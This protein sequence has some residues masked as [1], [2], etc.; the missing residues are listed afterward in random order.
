MIVNSEEKSR[1]YNW[2]KKTR[3]HEQGSLNRKTNHTSGLFNW[4]IL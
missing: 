2:Q 4:S 1:S 3:S